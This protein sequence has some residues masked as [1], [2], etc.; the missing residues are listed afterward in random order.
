MKKITSEEEGCF[1]RI[2]KKVLTQNTF[3]FD[4]N[5]RY[6]RRTSYITNVTPLIEMSMIPWVIPIM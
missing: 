4:F 1:Q 5:E 6:L 3:Y 2:N